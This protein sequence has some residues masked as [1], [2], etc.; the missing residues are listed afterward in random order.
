M[1]D[2]QPSSKTPKFAFGKDDKVTIDDIEYR[3]IDVTDTGYVFVRLDGEGVAESFSRTEIARLVGLGLIKH[4]PNAL[5]PE[6]ARQ[7][8]EL[9]AQLL[10][11]LSPEQ[12]RRAKGKEAV[13]QSFLDMEREGLVK[14]TDESIKQ[15]LDS[16]VGRAARKLENA[17]RYEERSR[18]MDAAAVPKF[19]ART[20]RRWL[21]AFEDLG[22]AGLYDASGGG[23]PFRRLCPDT[24]ALMSECVRGYL[25]PQ[26]PSQA[27]IYE[28]VKRAFHKEN[29]ARR[30]AGRAELVRPS[31]ETVRQAILSLDPFECAVAREGVEKARRLFSP[32]GTG[33]DLTYPL[34][35]VE[36]DTWKVD[37]IS[38]MTEAGLIPY[39]S[40]DEKKALGFTGQKKRWHLTVAICATTRCILAMRLSR[41]PTAQA[42]ISTLDMMMCD[43]GYWTDAV[44]A[45]RPWDMGGTPTL[46]V[47]DLG[48]EY[49]S[50][51]V[52]VAARDLGITV[53][54][55]PG[56]HPEMRARI[57]RFFRTMSIKLTARL[58]GRTFCNM[59]ERGDYDPKARAALTADDLCEALI[60]WV[61]DI[62]HHSPH[63]GLGGETPANCWNRLTELYGVQPSADLPRRRLAF[64]TRFTKTLRENGLTVLGVRYH[65]RQLAEQFLRR[66]DR[67]MNIR[68]YGEDI[69]A[70]AVEID[71][72]WIEV[73][74]VFS[75]FRGVRA[76]T[77][78]ATQ[79]ELAARFKHEA[80]LEEDTIFDAL[81]A[82][83]A[84]D[85]RARARVALIA[86]NW[87]EEKLAKQE[88]RLFIGFA[89]ESS[90]EAHGS[91]NAVPG[92]GEDLSA[93]IGD[94]SEDIRAEA[95]KTGDAVSALG[96]AHPRPPRQ[97]RH[98]D[99]DDGQDDPKFQI[100]DE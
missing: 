18:S 39:L 75:R 87:T 13:V 80:R 28:D 32:I 4:E 93:P 90:R 17:S 98:Q 53:E 54:H 49:N 56:G 3:P 78:L 8:L 79:R 2:F 9:P 68:W 72:Q 50:Y 46:I 19:S 99:G 86:D 27:D 81:D 41:T 84:I 71:G 14:R 34:Q 7:R 20:L 33:L 47:T 40:D 65:T 59:I 37:L 85:G 22:V 66:R 1:L 73:P 44:G 31:K 64:G 88:E 26:K 95:E 69:G 43:K 96:T 6:K 97:G 100:E 25:S 82:I 51:D 77:W 29:A 76:R 16:I 42:T 62:Y 48:S 74:S 52:R 58:T 5:L 10:S 38:L 45:L 83:E 23:N 61:V 91:G 60:R 55:A 15:A 89:T 92:F 24:L 94:A 36:L 11:A 57:E 67:E 35:R 12:H 70:I 21:R 30:E 63:Q